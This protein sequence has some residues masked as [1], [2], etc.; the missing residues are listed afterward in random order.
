MGDDD[1]G[2]LPLHGLQRLPN[3]KLA[4]HIDLAGR[5]IED[6][7]LR[8]PEDRSG[9]RDSLALATAKPLPPLPHDGLIPVGK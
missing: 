8:S 9:Q 1:D 7:D 5:F 3:F 4:I 2:E 6:Q